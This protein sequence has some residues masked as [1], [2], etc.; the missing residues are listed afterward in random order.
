MIWT[1]PNI[2]TMARI[3]AAP[4][5]ALMFAVFDR[6][7]ADW[8]ALG[9]FIVAALTDFLDG[10]LARKLNQ[11]SEFGKMLDPIADK[12]M[13]MV[14]L[15]IILANANPMAVGAGYTITLILIP[16][17][18]IG[19]REVL[20]S[21]TRE[22]LGDIKLPVTMI[23]KW[24]TTAQLVAVAVGL[25]ML[26][27]EPAVNKAVFNAITLNNDQVIYAAPVELLFHRIYVYAGTTTVVLFWIAALLT[28]ISGWDYFR[29]G[30]AY[31]QEKEG[32]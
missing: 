15:M 18:I 7:Q 6:P 19:T 8:I 22:Y 30:I 31:I 21:G 9:L 5:I 24:K 28:L 4:V 13:V 16:A 11:I 12:V 3:L 17:A 32:Q 14:G 29:K 26:A 27:F 23:A 25:F 2:L 1:I 20:I 10:W